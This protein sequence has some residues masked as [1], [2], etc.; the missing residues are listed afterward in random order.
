MR[1][2]LIVILFVGVG[3]YAQDDIQNTVN[4]TIDIQQQTQQSKEEWFNEKPALTARYNNAKAEIDYLSKRRDIAQNKRDAMQQSVDELS[5]R[6]DESIRLRESLIDTLNLMLEKL[7]SA[8][9]SDIP[10]LRQE[11]TV[12]IESLQKDMANPNI[13]SAEKLR[14]LLEAYQ[15]EAGYGSTVE[16]YP[17][18]IK[19]DGEEVSVDVLRIGRLS[20]F[21]MTPDKKMCG[22]YDVGSASW[23]VLDS[24][25]NRNISRAMEMAT[26]MR[27]IELIDLPLGRIGS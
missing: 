23:V 14:R 20:L 9:E 2:I 22:E 26:R 13:D 8:V 12:R 16:V 18:K 6:L 4:G 19:I 17:T 21:W 27:P 10:F 24:K 25:H 15:V 1:F 3:L 11:R 7:E 5:R